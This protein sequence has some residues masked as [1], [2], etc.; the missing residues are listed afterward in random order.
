MEVSAS[1]E[2][3]RFSQTVDHFNA[4]CVRTFQQRYYIDD[5]QWKA[6]GPLLHILGGESPI[7][8]GDVSGLYPYASQI[9]ARSLHAMVLVTEHRYFGES[10]PF[11][12]NSSFFIR[13]EAWSG[14][15]GL[16]NVE[17]AL[18]DFVAVA[19]SVKSA[20][21]LGC[22][23][24]ALGGSYPGLLAAMIRV[25]YPD[26]VQA[27]VAAS[28][29]LGYL[30]GK[31]DPYG[32]FRIIT[33]AAA[34]SHPQCPAAVRQMFLAILQADA[35]ALRDGI[36][37]CEEGLEGED[38]RREALALA[39][40]ELATLA[41]AN[42]PP[43]NSSLSSACSRI[44][45]AVAAGEEGLSAAKAL[46][47]PAPAQQCRSVH[48]EWPAGRAASIECVDRTGCGGGR[49]GEAWD[50][51]GCTWLRI[52]IAT[53]NVSDMFPVM[54]WS[55]DWVSA[56]CARRFE[57]SPRPDLLP[58]R[59]G[60]MQPAH[61]GAVTSRIIFTNGLRDGWSAGGL[62]QSPGED[63]P[64]LV[65]PNGA[66]CSEMNRP[67]DDD[68][69]DIIQARRSI[70][71]HLRAW[72]RP[73]QSTASSWGM[74]MLYG[75]PSVTLAVPPHV[76]FFTGVTLGCCA[77]VLLTFVGLLVRRRVSTGIP[78]NRM[79]LLSSDLA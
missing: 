55:E 10:L 61:L 56:Y 69:E 27:S 26:E 21:C 29:P 34:A 47:L 24:V 62:L 32:W 33:E 13:S 1:F 60:F 12:P 77:M 52:P 58:G 40:T 63:M 41:M 72:L 64:A 78:C 7:G 67:R 20:H 15:M 75:V 48:K 70:E 16:L 71:A 4:Q 44:V 11:G 28:A 74:S 73:P 43:R 5:S 76:A 59:F 57:V 37:L 8:A 18:R 35:S 22:P 49:A 25:R 68:T 65:M 2:A 50:Y 6:G 36:G 39:R 53:N 42:Y 54:H 19:A 46:L 38:I 14:G 3:F 23:V 17:Q 79:P 51:M 45:K 30:A 9:L 66:H 31:V